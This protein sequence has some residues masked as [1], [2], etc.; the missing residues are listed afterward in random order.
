MSTVDPYQICSVTFICRTLLLLEIIDPLVFSVENFTAFA[1]GVFLA[2]V[3]RVL[4]FLAG[5][6]AVVDLVA[7]V[8]MK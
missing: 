5:F 2:V 8:G 3:L 4:V 6:V 7:V 1:T